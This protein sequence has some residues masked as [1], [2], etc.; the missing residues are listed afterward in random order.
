VAG[1][2]RELDAFFRAFARSTGGLDMS[3]VEQVDRRR[4]PVVGRR[5]RPTLT[6]RMKAWC[7]E[8]WK[9]P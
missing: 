3:W 5:R 2:D 6:E 7:A 1:S 8:N 4:F 9:D